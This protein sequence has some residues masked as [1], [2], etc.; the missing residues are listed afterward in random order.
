[1]TV[2]IEH[3]LKCDYCG[4]VSSAQPNYP[5][6]HPD[7]M[8]RGWVWRSEPN[9]IPTSNGFIAEGIVHFCTPA[10][11]DSWIAERNIRPTPRPLHVGVD[12]S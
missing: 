7:G 2:I 8:P 3:R 1:M 6:P 12:N 10:H 11:R 9:P 4:N 5:I